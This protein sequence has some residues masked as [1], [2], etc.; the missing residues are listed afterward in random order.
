M[1]VAMSD[2]NSEHTGDGNRSENGGNS[3]DQAPWWSQGQTDAGQ[4]YQQ[5]PAQPGKPSPVQPGQPGQQQPGQGWQPQQPGQQPGSAYGQP[6]AGNTANGQYGQYGQ[7]PPAGQQPSYGQV[8]PSGQYGSYDPNQY[9][10]YGQ[11][12]QGFNGYQQL[13][14]GYQPRE[15]IVAGLLGIFLGCFG[16]HNFYLGYT[17]KAVLQLLLTCVGW[18]FFG[19]GPAAA[20]I[21]GLV[22][23]ILILCSNYGSPWH[24]DSKGV[25]LKD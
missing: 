18:I 10:Q 24:R 12:G 2:F 16:V 4:P 14:Y 15:K 21:W 19:L 17:T 8:P 5:Q 9:G 20:A 3:S 7:Y 23:G 11:Q 25:E 13:P 1:V 6:N 22:E